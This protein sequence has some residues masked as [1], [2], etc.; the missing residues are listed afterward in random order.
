MRKTSKAVSDPD[1]RAEY[2]FSCMAGGVRGKYVERYRA[3]V[4]LALLEPEVA[5]AFPTDKAVNEALRTAMRAG[6]ASRRQ[7]VLPN[8]QM[9]RTRPAQAKKPRR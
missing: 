8:K 5:E 4:N 9:Q 1:L 6:K 3:G 7:R 2:D